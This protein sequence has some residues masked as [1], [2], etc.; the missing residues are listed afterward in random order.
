MGGR[1]VVKFFFALLLLQN[2]SLFAQSLNTDSLKTV[3]ESAEGADK[4]PALRSLIRSEFRYNPK[5]ALSMAEQ[6][7][8]LAVTY[9]DEKDMLWYFLFRAQI[10]NQNREADTINFYTLKA[11]PRAIASGQD[12]LLSSLYIARGR[13]H[14]EFGQ[15]D[16]AIYYQKEALAINE[17]TYLSV[18]SNLGGFYY[19]LN[20]LSK[21]IYHY[22]LTHEEAIK[23]GDWRIQKQVSNNLALIFA[24]LDRNNKAKEYYMAALELLEGH[25]EAEREKL[26][27]YYNL[28]RLPL[29]LEEKYEWY[30]KGISLARKLNN[31]FGIQMFLT[32]EADLLNREQ[33][34]VEALAVVEPMYKDSTIRA[35]VIKANMLMH[36]TEAY[37]GLNRWKEAEQ[38]GLELLQ[39]GEATQSMEITQ[40]AR[41][42]LL[43]VYNA[44]GRS[45]EYRRIA[46]DYYPAK[47]SLKQKNIQQQIAFLD[48]ELE[49]L[50]QKQQIRELDAS[51][52]HKEV[53]RRW[54]LLV[55][56]LSV[57]IFSLIIYLRNRQLVAQRRLT[58]QKQK[59]AEEFARLNKELKSLDAMKSRFFSNI[60]HELRTPL[61]LIKVPLEEGLKQH[62]GTIDKGLE[63]TIKT[64]Y[65]NAG[66]LTDFVE[67]LLELSQIEAGKIFSE[68][69][70]TNLH[71]YLD[72]LFTAFESGAKVKNLQYQFENQLPKNVWVLIDKKFISKIVNNLLGNALKFTPF[73]GKVTLKAAIDN[74]Q[75]FLSVTDTGRGIAKEDLPHIFD[76]YFQSKNKELTTAGGYGIGLA[77]VKELVGIM[78]GQLTVESEWGKGSTF[79]MSVPVE[80]TDAVV[81]NKELKVEEQPAESPTLFANIKESA[82]DTP[83]LLIVEDNHDMQHLL[84]NL[85][86]DGYDYI[87]ANNGAEA[88]SMLENKDPKVNGISLIL[89]DIMMPKMD[90]YT[91]LE[92]IKAHEYW[93]RIPVVMLTALTEEADKLQ[94]LR[95]GVDDYLTK[96]FSAEELYARIEN[97]IAKYEEREAFKN[98]EFQ[99]EFESTPSADEK[100]LT[101]LKAICLSAIDRQIE[102][103]NNYLA[104]H[105]AISVRQLQRQIKALTGMTVKQYVQEARLQ[106]ALHL[107]ENRAYNTISEVAYA[108]G[109][110]TPSYFSRQ[111]E[112][113]F[114]KRPTSYFE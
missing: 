74:N 18:N 6:Y 65:N 86:A 109:F 20:D 63:T 112:K 103:N 15:L 55:A 75:L 73:G 52:K 1:I 98:L 62:Q 82:S 34:Y 90:G 16:S 59:T 99:L 111:F 22:Q 14:D 51:L 11:I 12:T 4:M 44:Q 66:K 83:K 68:K 24:A 67:E 33:K 87:I 100:W 23:R 45:E 27:V 70:P 76:R 84:V 85:L 5:E 35:S 32:I 108:S 61:T 13:Y 58:E 77:L 56:C 92:K 64:A 54:L 110:N 105:F 94:A 104:N 41:E 10:A 72:Q 96:P 43:A 91:L 95:Q 81:Q 80:T 53:Q 42:K 97:L 28:S 3:I 106:K 107:L 47:D 60:S 2:I 101:D 71:L 39:L 46:I 78:N 114:G 113:R 93:R 69:T 17:D 50:E 49:D 36:M 9:G 26:S 7:K 40:F 89:S 88:W 8:E 79:S 19:K 30:E 102:L 38:Y 57:I 25:E 37:K 48:A 21:S 31:A 29:P